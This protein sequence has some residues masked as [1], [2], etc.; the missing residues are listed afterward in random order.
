MNEITDEVIEKYIKND[1]KN[2]PYCGNENLIFGELE[3]NS[4]YNVVYRDVTCGN[5]HRKW[6]NIFTLTNID[7]NPKQK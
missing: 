1:G 6:N 7:Y 5:C 3:L 2:C 4:T